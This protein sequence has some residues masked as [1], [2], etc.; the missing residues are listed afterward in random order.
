MSKIF[1]SYNALTDMIADQIEAAVA[2][3]RVGVSSRSVSRYVELS[4]DDEDGDQIELRRVR[5]SDHENRSSGGD[6]VYEI[7]IRDFVIEEINDDCGEFDHIEV[8]HDWKIAEA[9]EAAIK[10]LR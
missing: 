9:I 3:S 2:G 1:P 8:G 5:I 6:I 7:D 4:I 10:A